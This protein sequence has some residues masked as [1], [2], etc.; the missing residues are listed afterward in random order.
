MAQPFRRSTA[1]HRPTLRPAPGAASYE[2]DSDAGFE[3][4]EDGDDDSDW[5]SW[6]D[7]V[8]PLDALGKVADRDG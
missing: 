5:A 7:S 6:E 4:S 3:L 1:P 8:Q 2:I